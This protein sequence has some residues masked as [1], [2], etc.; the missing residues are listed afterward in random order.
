M[1]TKQNVGTILE[2]KG[3]VVDAVFP[4][5][6][7]AIYTA[8]NILLPGRDEPLIAEGQQHLGDDHRYLH[9]LRQ[10]L[11]QRLGE[12]RDVDLEGLAPRAAAEVPDDHRPL[13]LGQLTVELEGELGPDSVADERSSHT[14]SDV[15]ET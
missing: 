7:P 6:L 15:W 3:V 11:P 13:E 1:S 12:R 4:E 5:R 2:V 14:R 10:G 8:L 9:R